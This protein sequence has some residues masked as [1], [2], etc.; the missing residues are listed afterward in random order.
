[1]MSQHLARIQNL[2]RDQTLLDMV[3]GNAMADALIF[4]VT[5]EII[6][7]QNDASSRH[8]KQSL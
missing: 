4:D 6:V 5:T 2:K 3:T 1:M 7:N 8:E